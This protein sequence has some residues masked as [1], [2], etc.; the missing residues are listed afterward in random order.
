[1]GAELNFLIEELRRAM[2]Y[3]PRLNARMCWML[4]PI[5]YDLVCAQLE[6]Y[7][8][9]HE[10]EPAYLGQLW[11]LGVRIYPSERAPRLEVLGE[12]EEKALHASATGDPHRV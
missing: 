8:S 10:Q 4:H 3:V 11:V 9:R 7:I 12:E 6:D 5:D 1:M 2:H